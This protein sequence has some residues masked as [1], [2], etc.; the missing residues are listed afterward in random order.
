[1]SNK[2]QQ[3]TLQDNRIPAKAQPN[4]RY[5]NTAFKNTRSVH[6]ESGIGTGAKTDRQ[7]GRPVWTIKVFLN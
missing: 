1:M 6:A 2:T 3:F 4:P 5:A 7:D